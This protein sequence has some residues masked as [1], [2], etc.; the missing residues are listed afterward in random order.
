MLGLLCYLFQSRSILDIINVSR[1]IPYETQNSDIDTGTDSSIFELKNC[2][3]L[4]W[5]TI[6][7]L[8]IGKII[9][10]LKKYFESII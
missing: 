8:I 4:P 6:I 7:N 3:I 2:L 1:S 5:K 10:N 9:I